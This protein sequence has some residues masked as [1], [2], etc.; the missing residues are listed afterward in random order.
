MLS[1]RQPYNADT[2]MGVVV[3]HITEPVPEIL[4]ANPDL[5]ESTD[6]I[7]KSAMAKDKQKRYSTVTDMARALNLAAFGTENASANEISTPYVKIAPPAQT[8]SRTWP[9]IGVVVVLVLL[10]G[11]FF[12]R[13]QL[14]IPAT[15]NPTAVSSSTP[16]PTLEPSATAP[17]PTPTD[18]PTPTIPATE[19]VLAPIC[20]AGT[21]PAVP[22]PVVRETNKACIKKVPYTTIS[23]PKDASFESLREGFSCIKEGETGNNVLISCTGRQLFSFDL[24][25]CNPQ[26]VPTLVSPADAGRCAQ[27]T[28]FDAANQCCVSPPAEDASCTIFKVDLRACL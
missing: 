7:I 20:P 14:F 3:K 5:P 23:I 24:K 16:A 4:R 9:I 17:I 10:V 25:V 19:V 6:T 13:N 1:G 26:P 21:I 8:G 22:K 27:G 15:G 2:P 12:L 11:G 28:S 18:I